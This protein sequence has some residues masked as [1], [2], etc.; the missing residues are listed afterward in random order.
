MLNLGIKTAPVTAEAAAAVLYMQVMLLFTYSNIEYTVY[1]V[2]TETCVY[3]PY[4]CIRPWQVRFLCGDSNYFR[5]SLQFTWVRILDPFQNNVFKKKT[6]YREWY[7]TKRWL[8][9]RYL[10]NIFLEGL[11]Y[12]KLHFYKTAPPPHGYNFLHTPSQ[13]R[14]SLYWR[15]YF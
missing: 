13:V 6:F 3:R 7:L 2:Y 12:F 10:T 14:L 1:T 15:H 5:D 8:C 11:T 9:K 4:L